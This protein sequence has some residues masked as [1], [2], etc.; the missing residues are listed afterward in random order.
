M[1]KILLI[2]DDPEI[3]HSLKEYLK[4]EGFSVQPVRG[5]R[6]ALAVMAE[7]DF[8]LALIDITLSDGNGFNVLEAA[9]TRKI[10][11]IFLTASG[12]ESTLVKGFDLGADEFISK[13]FRPRELVARI[14]NILR[15]KGKPSNRVRLQDVEVDLDRAT[16]VKD[17]KEENLS[18]LEHQL[19]TIFI[20]HRGQVLTRNQLL[21]E[22]W[23]VAGDFVNDNTLSVYI[24]RLREKMER[25]PKHPEIITTVWGMGYRLE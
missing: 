11:S 14:R 25:D 4:T 24:K 15:L 5:E 18:P 9:K 7:E 20:N 16:L 8:D 6:D 22:I 2:E 10:P 21:E 1:Q 13:P 3:V 17:N 12:D 19:L 23:D